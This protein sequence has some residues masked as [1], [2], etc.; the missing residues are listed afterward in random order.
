VFYTR[1]DDDDVKQALRRAS[2]SYLQSMSAVNTPSS[3]P[4]KASR[5]GSRKRTNDAVSSSTATS[6]TASSLPAR[7]EVRF[8]RTHKHSTT[9]Y[10]L[11]C[12]FFDL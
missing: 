2:R 3:T 1:G 4:I 9:T 6:T 5:K 12:L 7:R 8:V 10:V 11:V